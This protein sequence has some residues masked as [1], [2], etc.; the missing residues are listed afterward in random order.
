MSALITARHADAWPWVAAAML[1]ETYEVPAYLRPYLVGEGKLDLDYMRAR[2]AE[3]SN[4]LSANRAPGQRLPVPLAS[5][6]AT[7]PH[8]DR[9]WIEMVTVGARPVG[10]YQLGRADQFGPGRR[11]HRGGGGG[12]QRTARRPGGPAAAVGHLRPSGSAAGQAASFPAMRSSAGRST[13]RRATPLSAASAPRRFRVAADPHTLT[14]DP[15]RWRPPGPRRTRAV[16]ACHLHGV[17]ADVPAIRRLLP[18]VTVIEDVAQA[19][20]SR[21]D[22]L[23]AGTHG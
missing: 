11:S 18:G 14:L 2:V 17:C 1:G 13:G 6:G 12:V 10:R 21:L 8:P 5:A 20:G 22:G 23:L 9:A 7:R 19:L 16:I 15:A 3:L 4:A